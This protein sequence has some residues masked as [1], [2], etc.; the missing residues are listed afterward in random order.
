MAHI[1]STYGRFFYMKRF[2]LNL[3]ASLG[4][5][6]LLMTA[7]LA[8]DTILTVTNVT[9]GRNV[10]FSYDDLLELPQ[11]EFRTT[12]IWKSEV[13]SYSGPSLATVLDAAKMPYADLRIYAIN[14]YAADFPAKKIE[15]DAPILTI[16]VN[17]EPF[18]VRQKGPIWLLFPFDDNDDYRTE[19]NFALSVWQLRQI[20]V[21][22]E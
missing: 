22:P 17:G 20:D 19:D 8:E 1:P 18:S 16:Q 12:T 21:L 7:A 4:T 11:I 2:M 9:E 10:S 14:D 6:L 13:D 5:T 3:L 15:A